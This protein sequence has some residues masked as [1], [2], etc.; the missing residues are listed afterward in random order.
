MEVS[1]ARPHIHPEQIPEHVSTDILEVTL[2]S[3]LAFE[4]YLKSHPEEAQRFEAR[5]A[6][7][8]RR[9]GQK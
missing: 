2:R 4:Q 6:E 7:V 8:K 1:T 3:Y 5:V 9:Y